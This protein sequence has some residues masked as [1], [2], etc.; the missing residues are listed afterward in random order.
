MKGTNQKCLDIMKSTFEA[1]GPKPMIAIP[2]LKNCFEVILPVR[3]K[4]KA[5]SP[6]KTKAKD[7]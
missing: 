4:K 5:K 6:N 7:S 2:S 1:V 3:P